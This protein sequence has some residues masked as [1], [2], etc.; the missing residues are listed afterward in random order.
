MHFARFSCNDVSLPLLEKNSADF[1]EMFSKVET[2]NNPRV[3]GQGCRVCRT[4]GRALEDQQ[5]PAAPFL[6][7]AQASAFFYHLDGPS[8]IGHWAAIT[9]S[10]YGCLVRH[11]LQEEK[12]FLMP[13]HGRRDLPRKYFRTALLGSG[14]G[15]KTRYYFGKD[16]S[17]LRQ[18]RLSASFRK[19]NVQKFYRFILWPYDHTSVLAELPVS[20][21]LRGIFGRPSYQIKIR[22]LRISSD[23]ASVGRL[24]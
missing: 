13:K 7:R 6:T 14:G 4:G 5:L 23:V 15:S 8:E 21:A 12:S 17:L 16:M 24:R 22:L 20:S 3:P 18:H 19:H 10:C 1:A 2:G 9:L 11:R